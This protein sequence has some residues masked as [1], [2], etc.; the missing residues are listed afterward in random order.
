VV[1]GPPPRDLPKARTLLN[2]ASAK[3]DVSKQLNAL[4]SETAGQELV[5]A[6]SQ[7]PKD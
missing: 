2:L 7:P 6:E 4:A 3:M 5:T 1:R